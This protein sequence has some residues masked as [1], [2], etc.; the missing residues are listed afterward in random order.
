MPSTVDSKKLQP[1]LDEL[2]VELG[3]CLA[4]REA[5]SL[6]ASALEGVDALTDS[7][8]ATEG[9][10]PQLHKQQ[11]KEVRERVAKYFRAWSTFF[12]VEQVRRMDPQ[13]RQE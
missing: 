2:C 12:V 7:V 9:L 5:V 6:T 10:D 4:T 13:R 1:L 3:F 8:L 11:R